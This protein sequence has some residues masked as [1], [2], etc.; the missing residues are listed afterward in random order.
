MANPHPINPS[1][2]IK[3]SSKTQTHQA[4]HTPLP[5]NH[6]Y[7]Y[8]YQC[9]KN[10]DLWWWRR[11]RPPEKPPTTHSCLTSTSN[12]LCRQINTTTTA[13]QHTKPS[14]SQPF[15]P[16]TH[17]N[18][19]PDPHQK[20]H[21]LIIGEVEQPIIKGELECPH[22]RSMPSKPPNPRCHQIHTTAKS[23]SPL[24][25]RWTHNPHQNMINTERER[26]REREREKA[27]PFWRKREE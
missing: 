1:L 23:T 8:A 19:P 20:N 13:P 14:N 17:H 11:N 4:K 24:D 16:P 3:P 9:Q 12:H 26:E 15:K 6:H 22:Q 27:R 21:N 10:D 25:L 18:P 2:P 5:I 7:K